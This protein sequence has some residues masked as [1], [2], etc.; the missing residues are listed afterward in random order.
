ML[1]YSEKEHAKVDLEKQELQAKFDKEVAGH[2]KWQEGSKYLEKL[3]NSPQS[4][5]SRRALGYGDYIG[6]DEVYDPNEPS[7]FDPE[8]PLQFQTLVKYIKEGEM[9]TVSPTITGTFM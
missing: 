6:P 5:R 3:I 7:V 1:K 2:K 4:T 8:P 9:H